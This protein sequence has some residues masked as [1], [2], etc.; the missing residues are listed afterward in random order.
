MQVLRKG[1]ALA[2]FKR[3]VKRAK[4]RA[5]LLDYDGTLAPFHI[6]RDQAF[7]YPGITTCL[8]EILADQRT[9]LVVISGRS[10]SDL[11]P[12][13]G[14]EKLP[15]LWGSHGWERKTPDGRYALAPLDSPSEAGLQQARAW[16]DHVGLKEQC[17]YKP[18]SLAIHWRGSTEDA[19][20]H[21]RQHILE[22]WED[23][24]R[25]AGLVIAPFDGGIELRIP[26]RD[27]GRVV[28]EILDSLDAHSPVAFLGDDLTD[29]DAFIALGHRGLSILVRQELRPTAAD[30]WLKPPEEVLEFFRWWQ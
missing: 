6:Q 1:F 26:G 23:I 16:V 7:P 4:Q 29:E 28:R 22:G 11:I 9:R 3:R 27:K 15:E 20:E 5:L 2:N 18:A 19:R 24:A 13:L 10:I 8:S 14:M 30:F 17:E 21:I 25:A 12:L